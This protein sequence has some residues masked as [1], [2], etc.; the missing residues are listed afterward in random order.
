MTSE[1]TNTF[2]VTQ[3]EDKLTKYVKILKELEITEKETKDLFNELKKYHSD[4]QRIESKGKCEHI[5]VLYSC[6]SFFCQKCLH[7]KKLNSKDNVYHQF[8]FTEKCVGHN[9]LICSR[10]CEKKII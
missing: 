7:I 5:Y 6:D 3:S 9:Y 1:K 10:C 4:I 2:D 8:I